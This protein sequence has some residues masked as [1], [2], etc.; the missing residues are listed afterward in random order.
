MEK[1]S[2]N[3]E[4]MD[5][6]KDPARVHQD[7][8][9]A[10][11]AQLAQVEHER[12]TQRDMKL[13]F[14]TQAVRLGDA[15]KACRELA[16]EKGLDLRGVGVVEEK[17]AS[18]AISEDTHAAETSK[19]NGEGAK[20]TPA[21]TALRAEAEKH[22][23]LI[24]PKDVELHEQLGHGA[25]ADIYRGEWHGLDVAVKCLRPTCFGE[26]MEGVDV[27][28]REV[29]VL[30]KQRHPY[31]LKLLATVLS[32]PEHAWIVTE[33]LSQGTLMQWLHGTKKREWKRIIPL[34]PLIQRLQIATEI[35]IGMQYLH[36]RKPMVMHRDLKPSNVFLD[37]NIHVR[38]ADFSFSRYKLSNKE[39]YTGETGTYLYMAPEVM[40][41]EY[42]DEKCD[43]YSFAVMLCEL[44]TG[45]PPYIDDYMTPVQIACGV[46]DGSL[47]P[48]IPEDVKPPLRS[49]ITKSWDQIPS[50]RPT[51]AEITATLKIATDEAIQRAANPEPAEQSPVR[52]VHA[53]GEQIHEFFSGLLG[54]NHTITT[55]PSS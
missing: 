50:K 7:E 53:A 6:I 15:L 38:I 14:K 41:H 30:S 1:S 27:F 49:L 9:D 8:V 55:H 10:L 35:S 54:K 46:A 13:A 42:Y 24:Q 5:G 48:T 16:Q 31:V 28:V 45:N 4:A 52:H 39:V 47:R 11:R 34:P 23:W 12:D 3:S 44:V 20:A 33:Y 22:G 40:R 36:G 18:E 29:E 21:L 26:N 51:F 32:P 17:A 25:T 43:V 37:E 2:E 19:E